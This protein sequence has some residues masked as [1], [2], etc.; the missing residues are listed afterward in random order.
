MHV[1]VTNSRC[2]WRRVAQVS[3][4]QGR[5]GR[6]WGRGGAGQLHPH[7]LYLLGP[8]PHPPGAGDEYCPVRQLWG[9]FWPHPQGAVSLRLWA[10]VQQCQACWLSG[11]WL[12]GAWKG[13]AAG[14][15][16][17]YTAEGTHQHSPGVL[18]KLIRS[19]TLQSSMRGR[20]EERAGMR[21]AA[22][23]SAGVR[24]AGVRCAGMRSAALRCAGVRCAGV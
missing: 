6:R 4:G 23:R 9:P 18:S 13:G 1:D 24:C 12:G 3:G 11:T 19:S 8:G 17:S 20:R 22:L 7:P 14:W 16:R 15:G 2:S 10:L 5:C 21:S